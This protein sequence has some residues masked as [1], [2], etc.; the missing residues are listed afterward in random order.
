[1]SATRPTPSGLKRDV[2]PELL[3]VGYLIVLFRFLVRAVGRVFGVSGDSSTLLTLVVIGSAARAVR[4][5]LAA[6]RKQVRKARSSPT[7]VGDT[8]I[9][10]AAFKE[11]VD[12]IAGHPSRDTSFAAV[13]IV[14][15]VLTHSFRPAVAGSL[16]ALRRSVRAVITHG[17]RLRAWFA[18]RGAMIAARS[19]DVVLEAAGANPDGGSDEVSNSDR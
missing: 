15:A 16:G 19:R 13:L 7:F 5:V 11:T 3:L 2:S 9:G 6:P 18:A 17:L 1:M 12:S 4:R 10:T 8:M 14:F